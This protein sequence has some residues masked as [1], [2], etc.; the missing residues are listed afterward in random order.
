MSS[1]LQSLLF[2]PE[3]I[4]PPRIRT[5]KKKLV[6]CVKTQRSRADNDDLILSKMSKTKSHTTNDLVALTGLSIGVV[7]E[8]FRRLSEN[9]A[10]T[11]TRPYIQGSERRH[12]LWVKS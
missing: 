10:I 9:G 4:D 6:G 2:P 3:P 12:G 11:C 5:T 8:S 7:R 1:I